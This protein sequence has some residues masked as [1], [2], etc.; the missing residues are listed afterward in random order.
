MVRSESV[1]DLVIGGGQGLRKGWPDR[2]LGIF[3]GTPVVMEIKN[4]H[5]TLSEAQLEMRDLLLASGFRYYLFFVYDNGRLE[6]W[7]QRGGREIEDASPT[8][9]RE[10]ADMGVPVDPA[11]F[12]R[13]C[14]RT[15]QTEREF[16]LGCTLRAIPEHMK[17]EPE[18][19]P[20]E[21]TK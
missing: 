9:L 20:Q 1:A 2:F 11:C 13:D 15:L 12:E 18:S 10:L 8:P 5:D 16:E 7:R 19:Q 6:L 3:Q 4:E 17:E 21:A 14:F